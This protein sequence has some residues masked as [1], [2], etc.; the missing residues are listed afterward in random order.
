MPVGLGAVTSAV[1]AA[2]ALRGDKMKATAQR[3]LTLLVGLLLLSLLV[4]AIGV[5]VAPASVVSG[6]GGGG[7]SAPDTTSVSVTQDSWSVMPV[8]SA[9]SGTINVTPSSRLAQI[10][11][12]HG[13]RAATPAGSGT[14]NAAQSAASSGTPSTTYWL[15]GAA[16]AV[17][18]AGMGAWALLRRRRQPAESASAAYCAQH[19]EDSLCGAA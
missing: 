9:G 11:S 15:I 18:I 17:L 13:F 6:S 12:D 10:Q 8:A 14:I 2:P 7:G 4:F 19:P 5:P 3:R 1:T 16:A